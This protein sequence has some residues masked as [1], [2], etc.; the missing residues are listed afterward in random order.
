MIIRIPYNF[1]RNVLALIFVLIPV[2][3]LSSESTKSAPVDKIKY[4]TGRDIFY[5]NN[6]RHEQKAACIDCHTLEV[7]DTFAWYPSAIDIAHKFKSQSTSD[8]QQAFNNPTSELGEEVH[9]G[10]K[11][12]QAQAGRIKYFLEKELISNS[13]TNSKKKKND[14][15]LL[16]IL[17]GVLLT[18]VIADYLVF[19]QLPYKIVHLVLICVFTILITR[20]IIKDWRNLDYQIHYQPNQPIKFSHQ[21]HCEQNKI[22]C[23]YC[24]HY[25]ATQA[26]AGM[27]STDV[28]M[29]C[30][31]VI[32]E[33][34]NSGSF[35]I[36]K[37]YQSA[38]Q[39]NPLQ[40]FKVYNI[41]DH[42]KFYH[43]IHLKN[44]DMEC[45]DCHNISN[46][47]EVKQ[48]PI[49]SMQWCMDCHEQSKIDVSNQDFFKIM[50]IHSNP[51]SLTL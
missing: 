11:L 24:H 19:K 3:V 2:L 17:F 5:G 29:N 22:D 34:A 50:N 26:A 44:G 30:H 38:E 21:V 47:H 49:V 6:T 40:W 13:Q 12:T 35:E 16:I 51:D 43:D 25:G 10:A 28:C 14:S 37:I 32:R 46:S 4:N 39:N 45:V 7:L 31:L 1:L 18:L 20:L 8:L 27:P 48:D 36:E 23:R 9:T 15:L 33:G 41:P 42:V